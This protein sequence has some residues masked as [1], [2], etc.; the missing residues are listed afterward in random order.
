[1]ADGMCTQGGFFSFRLGHSSTKNGTRY[2]VS[3]LVAAAASLD[4][5]PHTPPGNKSAPPARRR[6][7]REEDC[8]S[9]TLDGRLSTNGEKEETMKNG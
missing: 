1:M 5:K 6:L 3:M 9:A 7:R 8:R 4:L 2:K